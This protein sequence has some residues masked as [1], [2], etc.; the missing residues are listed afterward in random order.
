MTYEVYQY[1]AIGAAVSA[2]IM[3]AVSILLFFILR[4]PKVVGDVTGSTARKAVK[5]IREGNEQSG[6]KAYKTSPVNLAR[7]KITDKISP[8]GAIISTPSPDGTIVRTQKISTQELEDPSETAVL[9]EY[10]DSPTPTSGITTVLSQAEL[11]G[12]STFEVEFDI[13]FIHTNEIIG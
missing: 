4:I 2:G 12:G 13:T 1:L 10:L 7:G 8:S 6:D 3:F 5:A 11:V 9:S